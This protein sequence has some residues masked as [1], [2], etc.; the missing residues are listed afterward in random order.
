MA[1]LHS[2]LLTRN[3][4]KDFDLKAKEA[5]GIPGILLMENAARAVA[6]ECLKMVGGS[7]GRRVAVF[8]GKGNNG[9]DGFA[10]ARHLLTAGL[11]PDIFLA[12]RIKE[13]ENEARLNLM[14]LLKL[15]QKI[16]EAEER[17]LPFIKDRTSK[18]DLIIDALLG[19]GLN[20][21][22]RGI[23][24]DLVEIINSSQAKVLAVDIPSGLDATTG[25]VL[26]CC[27]RADKTVTFA[28]KKRGMLLGDGPR[29]CG[30]IIVG[31][32]GIPL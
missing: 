16:I 8:C 3:P 13:V 24:K 26:G 30:R 22:V 18:C 21:E 23:Y 12:A 5:L 32:L 14:I 4:A 10:A 9:G 25:E 7:K 2:K 19:V 27:V 20:G 28:A 31:D 15:K 11:K 1:R 6:E 17:N 29:H